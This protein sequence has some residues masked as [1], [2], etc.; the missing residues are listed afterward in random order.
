MTEKKRLVLVGTGGFGAYWCQSIIAQV[1]PFAELVAAVDAD[2]SKH[3]NAVEFC[4][5]S[6]DRCYT[7]V[8]TALDAVPADLV[9]VVVPPMFHEAVIDEALAH[10]CDIICEKPIAGALEDCVRILKKVRAAGRKLVTT[11]SHRYA[12]DKQTMGAVLRSGEY[13]PANYMVFRM[14]T[15]R[16]RDLFQVIPRNGHLSDAA[17]ILCEAGVHVMDEIREMCGCNARSVY[18]RAFNAS[19]E[20]RNNGPDSDCFLAVMEM[21]NGIKI[22][23]EQSMTNATRRNDWGNDY[24]RAECEH[25]TVVLDNRKIT[26]RSGIGYPAPA[27]AE[28]PLMEREDGLWEHAQIIRDLCCWIDGGPEPACSIE[29]NIHGLAMAFAAMESCRTGREVDP[30]ALLQAAMA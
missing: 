20:A 25:A 1:A 22:L 17:W 26:V 10:G 8:K 19:W 16:S 30:E 29:S 15:D 3:A 21:E 24:I 6:S 27:Y 5:L 13:G 2:P 23:C 12:Q 4:G 18:A 11:V 7:D 9:A 14:A 28:I